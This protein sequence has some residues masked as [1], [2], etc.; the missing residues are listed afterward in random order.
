MHGAT[1]K[2]YFLNFVCKYPF[3][4]VLAI[5]RLIVVRIS[6]TNNYRE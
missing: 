4:A 3:S 5:V 6:E 1:V 2:M